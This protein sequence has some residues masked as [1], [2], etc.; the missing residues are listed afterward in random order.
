[1]KI[2]LILIAGLTTTASAFSVRKPQTSFVSSSTALH[3]SRRDCL[4]AAS[5][6]LLLPTVSRAADIDYGKIQD[7]LGTPE[8]KPQVYDPKGPRPKYLVEP[9]EEFKQNEQAAADFKR[10]QIEK[11]KRFQAALDRLQEDPNDEEILAK[12]LDDLRRMV[13]E[14]GGLPEGIT[15]QDVVKQVR[16]R[17][18]KKYWPTNVEIA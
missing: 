11:K 16:L 10:K 7:L 18:K 17:K 4:T 13:K 5:S 15:K 12:D 8:D 14:M 2:A 9:T 1:M 6:L 3:V